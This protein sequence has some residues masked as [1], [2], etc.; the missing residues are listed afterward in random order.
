MTETNI[1]RC[2]NLALTTYAN[3]DLCLAR[4]QTDRTVSQDF[5]DGSD[6][7][8]GERNMSRG[9]WLCI[10]PGSQLQSDPPPNVTIDLSNYLP[11]LRPC[12]T[13]WEV[14]QRNGCT[15]LTAPGRSPVG[16]DSVQLECCLRCTEDN[17]IS[18]NGSRF[19]FCVLELL[20]L[21]NNER[22]H[23]AKCTGDCTCSRA[24]ANSQA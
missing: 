2:E 21:H 5:R 3:S 18:Q 7:G 13:G 1:P 20:A 22:M 9:R 6:G 19:S 15:L 12:P 14:L 8:H 23:K 11:N 16:M 4:A 17:P 24:C 10:T